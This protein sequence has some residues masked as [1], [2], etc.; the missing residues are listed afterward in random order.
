MLARHNNIIINSTQHHLNKVETSIKIK[1]P[2]KHNVANAVALEK[3]HGQLVALELGVEK[4]EE[5]GTLTGWSK[6]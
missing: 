6:L 4:V 3:Q 1:R 2:I 5:D